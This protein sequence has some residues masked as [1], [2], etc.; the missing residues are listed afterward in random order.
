MYRG[1]IYQKTSGACQGIISLALNRP[2]SK[3][4]CVYI[5]TIRHQHLILSRSSY[6]EE[7]ISRGVP[8]FLLLFYTFL[9]LNYH[10]Y[11]IQLY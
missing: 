6:L 9:Q 2:V 7:T 3:Q 8:D 1:Y 4:S 10:V 5:Q 11:I